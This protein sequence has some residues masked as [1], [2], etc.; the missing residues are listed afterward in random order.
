MVI[1]P[2]KAIFSVDRS[3]RRLSDG[4][5]VV[6]TSVFTELHSIFPKLGSCVGSV[7]TVSGVRVLVMLFQSKIEN[8][9]VTSSQESIS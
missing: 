2:T 6:V 1:T 7:S 8:L 4:V 3:P 5:R 9:H